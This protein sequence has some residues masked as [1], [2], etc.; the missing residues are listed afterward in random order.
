ML[1]WRGSSGMKSTI[2]AVA[3]TL[4]AVSSALNWAVLTGHLGS[5]KFEYARVWVSKDD[6]RL[7]SLER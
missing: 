7:A 1:S 5:A 6:Y 3:L 2:L 4:L